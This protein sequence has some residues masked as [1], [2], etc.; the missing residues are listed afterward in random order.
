MRACALE[1]FD[2][3][4]ICAGDLGLPHAIDAVGDLRPFEIRRKGG[5]I[6]QELGRGFGM[7]CLPR[8]AEVGPRIPR[9]AEDLAAAPGI[10]GPV[11]RGENHGR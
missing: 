4:L 2:D 8:D 1:V 6:E 5:G 9:L 10:A 3:D 11:T 7:L